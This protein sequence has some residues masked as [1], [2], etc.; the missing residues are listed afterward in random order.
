MYDCNIDNIRKIKQLPVLNGVS[1]KIIRIISDDQIEL[2]DVVDIIS[3]SPAITARILR[4]A[5]SAYFGQRAQ[6]S[7]VREAII[8]VLGLKLT[9]SLSLAMALTGSFNTRQCSTF[10]PEQYWTTSITAAITAQELSSYI[11]HSDKLEPATA[12]TAGLLH[13]IGIMALTHIFPTEMATIFAN[14]VESIQQ[15]T[16]EKLGIDQHQTSTILA[17]SWNLPESIVASMNYSNIDSSSDENS[18]LAAIV[19][20]SSQ[21][22]NSFYLHKNCDMQQLKFDKQ[23]IN[24][25]HVD[26]VIAEITTQ[27]EGLQEIAQLII[28]VQD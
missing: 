28:G 18:T 13:T 2:G 25:K 22:A 20:L 6:I 19:C 3:K 16:Q 15:Q 21:I 1:Q 12:Y 9:C 5:N 7:S 26:K 10:N 8:R 24:A 27:L 17:N 4:C 23:T 11:K 14:N